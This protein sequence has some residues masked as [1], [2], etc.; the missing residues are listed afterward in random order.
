MA[1]RYLK[2][3]TT[4]RLDAARCVG[5]G[6]CVTVCPQAVLALEDGKAAIQDRDACMECGACANNCPSAAISVQAGV[7]CAQAVINSALGRTSG[8]CC[9]TLEPRDPSQASGPA[10][11]SSGCC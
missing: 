8:S 10:P 9:C 7:G 5:C 1:L 6:L 3:V 2:N 4:L 11:K